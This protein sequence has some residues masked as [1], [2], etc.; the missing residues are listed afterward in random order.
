MTVPSTE[1]REKRGR[2]LSVKTVTSISRAI[3]Q[4][5]DPPVE[6]VGVLP[7]E[8][9]SD[10]AEIVVRISGCHAEPCRLVLNVSRG[11]TVE[12][13]S[14]QFESQ[15]RDAIATHRSSHDGTR[16]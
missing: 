3:A 9:A 4:K 5:H 7:S 8:G 10:R 1:R 12:E 16:R 13:F 15:L 11:L 6:L 14:N 2:N